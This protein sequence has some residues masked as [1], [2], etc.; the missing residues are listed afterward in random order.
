MPDNRTASSALPSALRWLLAVTALGLALAA[1]SGWADWHQTRS[2]LSELVGPPSSRATDPTRLRLLRER[3]PLHARILACR[4]LINDVMAATPLDRLPPTEQAPAIEERVAVLA[5]V[6]QLARQVLDEQPSNWQATMFLG[7]ATY[8]DLLL[9]QDPRLFTEARSWEAPLERALADA[10]GR[11]EPARFLVTTY[12]ELWYALSPA[13]RERAY[14]LLVQV[15]ARDPAAFSQ[16]V[17]TWL[18][19]AD[20]TEEA[21]APIPD[22]PQAWALVAGLYA[23]QH[24]WRTFRL[25]EMRRLDS[26]ELEL[27]Q[28]LEEAQERLRRGDTYSSRQLFMKVLN[29]APLDL[30][31]APLVSE[32]LSAAPAG[33]HSQSSPRR[34]KRWLEWSLELADLGHQP[35]ASDAFGRLWAVTGKLPPAQSARAAIYAGDLHSAERFERRA[36]TLSIKSWAPYLL[37]KADLLI[38][39]GLLDEAATALRQVDPASRQGAAFWRVS[40]RLG[41]AER[42]PAL[43]AQA[44]SKLNQLGRDG[45]LESEWQRTAG[46]HTL[47]LLPAYAATG[48]EIEIEDAPAQGDV[49]EVVLDGALVALVPVRSGH[50]LRVDLELSP[51]PHLLQLGSAVEASMQPGRVRLRALRLQP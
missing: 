28:A 40:G 12:L 29:T 36:D 20:D 21:F 17:P 35:L 11:P 48:L 13:K 42:D 22:D 38:T 4:I 19:L 18:Q 26:L 51:E 32:A 44:S 24:D 43:V 37:A 16:L 31:F 41:E 45:W 15:F 34:L 47:P 49:V 50:P 14:E 1:L 9:N 5:Q 30:R 3:T 2:Q 6:Q 8:M 27:R 46:R 33:I 25:A 10:A 7:A 39:R 23:E